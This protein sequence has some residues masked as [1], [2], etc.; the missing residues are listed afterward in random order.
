MSVEH[1]E[2]GTQDKVPATYCQL[3]EP[4]PLRGKGFPQTTTEDK[5]NKN[6]NNPQKE[7]ERK[8]KFH[9]RYGS[10]EEVFGV[11]HW[12]TGVG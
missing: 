7:R 1:E 11:F 5:E 4:C 6:L 10:F 8:R 9:V 2:Q 12:F 3:L